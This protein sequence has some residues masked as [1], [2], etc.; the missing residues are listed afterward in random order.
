MRGCGLLKLLRSGDSLGLG[1]SGFGSILILLGGWILG[2]HGKLDLAL[3]LTIPKIL[4]ASL[5]MGNALVT[6]GFLDS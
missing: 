6:L 4:T 5:R 3:R 1:D 2:W